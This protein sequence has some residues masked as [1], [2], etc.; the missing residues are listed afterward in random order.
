MAF[1]MVLKLEELVQLKLKAGALVLMKAW[2]LGFNEINGSKNL[3]V[4][5]K[6]CIMLVQLE[7]EFEVLRFSFYFRLY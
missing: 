7:L 5:D 6:N 3:M 4:V 1:G 2:C